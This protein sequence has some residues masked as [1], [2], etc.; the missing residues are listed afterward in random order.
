M[1][2]NTRGD[3]NFPK[4]HAVSHYG[5]AIRAFGH[6]RLYET[7]PY[8]RLHIP[9]CKRPYRASNK[10]PRTLG[11]QVRKLQV[12]TFAHYNLLTSLFLT[13][14]LAYVDGK[15]GYRKTDCTTTKDI[16]YK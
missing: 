7:S 15:E 9:Y 11:S 16:N 5:N 3:L 4:I 6:T 1:F 8:E 12:H 14:V 13:A 2:K 10:Q